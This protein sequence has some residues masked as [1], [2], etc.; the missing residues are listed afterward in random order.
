MPVILLTLSTIL[1][2]TSCR[3]IIKD[4][5]SR[6]AFDAIVKAIN[7]E[8]WDKELKSTWNMIQSIKKDTQQPVL[9]HGRFMSSIHFTQTFVKGKPKYTD[10]LVKWI[11]SYTLKSCWY[12]CYIQGSEIT[13]PFQ[14]RHYD[15]RRYTKTKIDV[16][17]TSTS[18]IEWQ[19]ESNK[20]ASGDEYVTK[21]EYDQYNDTYV[22]GTFDYCIKP[23]AI[24]SREFVMSRARSHQGISDAWTVFYYAG[25]L[26]G[27]GV[28]IGS[29]FMN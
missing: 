6:S 23:I 20:I 21:C 29:C 14:Y 18:N 9:Y 1:A 3:A 27:V 15:Q 4:H 19:V 16:C 12:R 8:P 25:L 5:K 2:A 11:P 10:L 24:G 26:A 17:L 28:G 22:Y 7:R 13:V